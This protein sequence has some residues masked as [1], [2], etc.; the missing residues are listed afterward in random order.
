MAGPSTKRKAIPDVSICDAVVQFLQ[1]HKT[2]LCDQT[3]RHNSGQC[4]GA[5]G[6]DERRRPP[7]VE[8]GG[9]ITLDLHYLYSEC[10]NSMESM[11]HPQNYKHV[12]CNKKLSRDGHVISKEKGSVHC[13]GTKFCYKFH[14]GRLNCT[15]TTAVLS[16]PDGSCVLVSQVWMTILVSS[17]CRLRTTFRSSP[18]LMQERT[19]TP[20]ALHMYMPCVSTNRRSAP[21]VRSALVGL[22]AST[23]ILTRK[24]SMVAEV[25]ND[26]SLS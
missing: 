14:P 26:G 24:Q 23:G 16:I 10:R 8:V 9:I 7:F 18:R 15:L 17:L 22:C 3:S 5:H 21:E 12:V 25:V 20:S 13:A 6:G 2:Y 4:S 19:W 1:T 11:F